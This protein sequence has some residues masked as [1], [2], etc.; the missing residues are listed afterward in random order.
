M[1]TTFLNTMLTAGL[2]SAFSLGF[3]AC[4][5]EK[6]KTPRRKITRGPGTEETIPEQP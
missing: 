6:S 4:S 1:K 3:T 5:S 2:L